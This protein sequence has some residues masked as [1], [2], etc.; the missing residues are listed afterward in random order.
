MVWSALF[1]VQRGQAQVAGFG[2]GDRRLHR[3]GVADLADQDHVRRLAHRVLQR[4]VEGVRVQ[5]DLALVDD[6][7]LV[8]VQVFDRVLDGEDVAR[9]GGVAVVDHRG[10]RRRLAVEPVEPTTSTSPRAP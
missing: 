9:C 2:E 3:L 1:G 8:P 4:V 5:A 7:L 6:R 10:Q